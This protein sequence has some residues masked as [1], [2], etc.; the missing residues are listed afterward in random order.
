MFSNIKQGNEMN[1]GI[2]TKSNLLYRLKWI[3]YK[4][5]SL[6]IPNLFILFRDNAP[7]SCLTLPQ[8]LRIKMFPTGIEIW[9]VYVKI[10]QLFYVETKSILRIE[11]SKQKA[12][13][14]IA[15]RIFRYKFILFKVNTILKTWIYIIIKAQVQKNNLNFD[16]SVLWY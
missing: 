4:T 16:F 2:R 3:L 5:S 9:S 8:E 7:L 6:L 10:F 15:R 11:K 13:S 14:F 1:F 12:S